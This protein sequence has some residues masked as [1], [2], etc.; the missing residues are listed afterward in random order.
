MMKKKEITVLDSNSIVR[1]TRM[2]EKEK[3]RKENGAAAAEKR[4]NEW[5]SYYFFRDHSLTRSA[6]AAA[7]YFRLFAISI[8]HQQSGVRNCRQTC[9]F[10]NLLF[11]H[12]NCGATVSGGGGPNPS[13]IGK[14]AAA[15]ATRNVRKN[16]KETALK[17]RNTQFFCARVSAE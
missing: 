7:I 15:A 16:K 1:I 9:L 10:F 3:K 12:A 4:N 11:A 13:S 2:N 8:N 14:A 6:A 17:T 5:P